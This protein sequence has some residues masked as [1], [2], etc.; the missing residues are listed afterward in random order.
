MNLAKSLLLT[1]A[2]GLFSLQANAAELRVGLE[3][4]SMSVAE[5]HNPYVA[6]WLENTDS[7]DVTNLEVWYDASM[8]NNKGNKWLK[9]MRQWWRKSGR[10]LDMPVDGITAATKGPGKYDIN[11]EIADEPLSNLPAGS[12]QLRV[13]AAREVGGRELLSIPFSWPLAQ[14][15]TASVQGSKELGEVTLSVVP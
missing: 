4:P 5:Y 7:R 2:A 12:Y 1:A 6:I 10:E 11:V 9:D 15:F 13:E 14:P 8:S 3:I